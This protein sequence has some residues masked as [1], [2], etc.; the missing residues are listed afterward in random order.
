MNWNELPRVAYKHI[1]TK[2]NFY[3]HKTNRNTQRNTFIQL[4]SLC[5]LSVDCNFTVQHFR[6]S[7]QRKMYQIV[8][9]HMTQNTL[10]NISGQIAFTHFPWMLIN[11]K[12]K[13]NCVFKVDDT[14]ITWKITV[15]N[16]SPWNIFTTQH[17]CL[18]NATGSTAVGNDHNKITTP[19]PANQ[20]HARRPNQPCQRP[21]NSHLGQL[22]RVDKWTFFFVLI[23]I[24]WYWCWG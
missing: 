17:L 19:A 16:I 23:S 13:T 3:G 21:K 5:C 22:E 10:K 12:L 1:E 8:T 20:K 15:G 6:G 2:Y 4:I 9:N 11:L 18:F 14:K 7:V 24:D